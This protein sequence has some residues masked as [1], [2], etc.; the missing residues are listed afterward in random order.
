MDLLS[1]LAVL[2]EQVATLRRTG[3]ERD[4]LPLWPTGYT[5]MAF[6]DGTVFSTQWE[7]VMSPRT[8]SLSL[9]LTFVGDQVT[10]TNTG[11]AWQVLLGGAV[12]WSGT[13]LPNFTVQYANTVLD[14][15]PYRG[16]SELLVEI[17]TRRTS[18]ATTGG[19]NGNGGSIGLSPRFARLL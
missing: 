4:E 1:R 8:A 6:N 17:Q 12:V 19:R 15:L 3:W 16:Q 10:G 9:G 14:L 18:G 13:V 5:G 2:E 7:S 11:G